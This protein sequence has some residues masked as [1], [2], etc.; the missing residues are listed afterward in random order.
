MDYFRYLLVKNS[1]KLFWP[2]VAS[3]AQGQTHCISVALIFTVK[4]VWTKISNQHICYDPQ[5]T[6]VVLGSPVVIVTCHDPTII[7]QEPYVIRSMTHERWWFIL[8][9]EDLYSQLP[10]SGCQMLK[11][12][13]FM[14]KN[15]LRQSSGVLLLWMLLLEAHR[16]FRLM[17]VDV[18]CSVD[19]I[20]K[21]THRK[22]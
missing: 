1:K 11:C 9:T 2:S 4:L 19:V 3:V 15:Q 5:G 21:P 12:R 7:E 20:K 17:T 8:K 22:L 14:N 18:Q 16:Y 13:D 10:P 6:K